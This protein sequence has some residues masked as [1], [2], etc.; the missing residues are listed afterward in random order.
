MGAIRKSSVFAV[1]LLG[2]F[3]SPARAEGIVTARVP[4]PFVVGREA[5]PAGQYEIRS[6]ADVGTV[7][8]IQ[9]I[10]NTSGGFALTIPADSGDPTGD[11]PALVFTRYENGYRL[12]QIWKSSTEGRKLPGPS[13]SKKTARAETPVS[14]SE[15]STY[16]LAANWK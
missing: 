10:N 8:A 16:V 15:A 3:V 13:A 9:G 14:P 6:V 12:S 11:Q 7:I 4:F 2:I 5:F 1:L